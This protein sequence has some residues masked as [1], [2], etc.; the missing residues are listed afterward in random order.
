MQKT[1]ESAAL[2]LASVGALNWGL[3]AFV[4]LDLV[5]ALFGTASL[6]SNILYGI[7]GLAGIYTLY[8][9]VQSLS[10]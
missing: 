9:F 3:V 8:M 4:N 1:I 6:I 5:A 10:K 2:L 7:V